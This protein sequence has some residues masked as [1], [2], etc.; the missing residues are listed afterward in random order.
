MNGLRTTGNNT[1]ISE[2]ELEEQILYGSPME[3]HVSEQQDLTDVRFAGVLR[4]TLVISVSMKNDTLVFHAQQLLP[5]L[6]HEEENQGMSAQMLKALR[7]CSRTWRA[8]KRVYAKLFYMFKSF[9][10]RIANGGS[11]HGHDSTRAP[12]CGTTR[13]RC[14]H[15]CVSSA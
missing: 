1:G 9:L 2:L 15:R 3:G 12:G 13:R 7:R 14:S 8:P 11:I 5:S 6:V 4:Q 10:H